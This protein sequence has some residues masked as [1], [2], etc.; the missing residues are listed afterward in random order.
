MLSHSGPQ[1]RFILFLI[2]VLVGYTFLLKL[3]QKLALLIPLSVFIPIT[4]FTLLVFIGIAGTVYS[5]RFVGPLD[6]IRRTLQQIAEG[7]SSVALRLREGDDPMLK[8][9][10]STIEQLCEH[11]RNSNQLVREALRDLRQETD[12]LFAGISAG[13]P[14]VELQ[15]RADSVRK[16]LGEMETAVRALGKQ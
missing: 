14:D 8:D 4:L 11:T 16:R 1:A 13:A 9:L 3:F 15:K 12:A 7:D 6:R 2:I 5:H 10:V